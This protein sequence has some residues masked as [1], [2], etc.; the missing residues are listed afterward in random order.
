MLA[1]WAAFAACSAPEAPRKT[2]RLVDELAN[3]TLDWPADAVPLPKG[4]LV[5]AAGL[6]GVPRGDE[7]RALQ[8]VRLWSR[9]AKDERLAL[10]APAGGSYRFALTLPERA[11]LRVDLAQVPGSSTGG[12]LTFRVRIAPAAGG[13][14][15]ALLERAV[16]AAEEAT[17]QEVAVPLERWGGERVVLELATLGGPEA[18]WG[19]WSSPRIDVDRVRDPR[20][21]VVLIS[22]DTLRA[23]HLGTYG[24]QI[25]TP[26]IDGVAAEG[27]VFET[28]DTA[29]TMTLP[30]HTSLFTG[31]WPA[32]HGVVRNGWLVNQENRMLPE[33]LR[34]AGFR[35]VGVSAAVAL[36]EQLGFPQ[37]F[38]VWNQD[39]ETF[40]N[41]VVANEEARRAEQITDAAIAELDRAPFERLF[42][43]VHYV[44][45]HLP[46]DPPEPWR[47]QYG[48][49][50]EGLRGSWE[51]VEKA[52]E[53]RR[54]TR[55]RGRM[56]L[57]A[58]EFRSFRREPFG[59]D[60]DLARLYAGEVAYL[61]HHV[62]RL[63]EAL[64]ER[65][66]VD[67]AV[68]A[69]TSDHGETFWEHGDAWSHGLATYQTTV[70]IPL[71]LRLPGGR[72]AGTRISAPVSNVDVKPTLLALLRL[73]PPGPLEGRSLIPL[74]EGRESA[75]R[76]VFSEGPVPD[77]SLERGVRF[78]ANERKPQSV[79]IGRWKYVRAPYAELEELYDLDTDPHEQ[80]DLLLE[81]T[82]EARARADELA[83][84]LDRLLAAS[85]P[86]PSEYFPRRQAGDDPDAAARR[87]MEERL[88]QL[89]YVED[90]EAPEAKAEP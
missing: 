60:L 83:A 4:S 6:A 34:E 37:G 77:G 21:S 48:P 50:P 3:A 76:P 30:S 74:L 53:R 33:V 16:R 23:D 15:V 67:D 58:E 71:I 14:G 20:P 81:P 57:T 43:F 70:R 35:T 55:V 5:G 26:N 27:I 24:S 82:P 80:R 90:A 85:K 11:T 89:G 31:N 52:R 41:H 51:V 45:P 63:L 73:P 9:P 75:P 49:V 68:I 7:P 78:W 44:D 22:L 25:R 47:S 62:G 86:L 66:I 84:E 8:V 19:A 54:G 2:I 59:D 28:A 13:E 69:I 79:R 10:V 64:R 72:L 18:G 87:A 32:T 36:S 40:E 46:Y 17:W 88:R 29:S 1:V 39:P 38:D 65:G 56:R 61:D 12:E 42:L